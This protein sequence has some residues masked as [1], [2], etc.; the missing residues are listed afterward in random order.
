MKLIMVHKNNKLF[1]QQKNLKDLMTFWSMF[2][3]KNPKL[4]KIHNQL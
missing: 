2:M 4:L 3:F 1:T